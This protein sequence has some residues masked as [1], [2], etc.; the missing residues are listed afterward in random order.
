[1]WMRSVLIRV[2]ATGAYDVAVAGGD[3]IFG[4]PQSYR[5]CAEVGATV[6]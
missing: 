4:D 6:D 2:S 3:H 5:C 1:M